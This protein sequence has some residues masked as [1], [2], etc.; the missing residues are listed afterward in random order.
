MGDEST[1]AALAL[2]G[3]ARALLDEIVALGADLDLDSALQRIIGAACRITSA[4]FGVLAV[5]GSSGRVIDFAF[6]GLDSEEQSVI[7]S[8]PGGFGLRG[9]E[10]P[11]PLTIDDLRHYLRSVGLPERHLPI[12]TFL[13]VPIRVRGTVF[14]N[15]YL[16][17]KDAG[18]EFTS[19]DE[20]LLQAL[21][22][23]AAIVVENARAYTQSERRRQWLEATAQITEALQPPVRLRS[24][25]QQIAI[26]ARR[27]SGAAAV[28]VVQRTDGHQE[29]VARDDHEIDLPM[30]VGDLERHIDR[31]IREPDVVIAPLA[32]EQKVILVPLRAMVASG[33]VLLVV[34]DGKRANLETEE[35]DML[36]SFADQASFALDRAQAIAD[37]AELAIVTDRDRIA[38]DLHD[39]V[40]QRLFATGLQLQGARRFA[41]SEEVMQRIDTAVADLDL[42]I[43][44]I[45]TTIFELQNAHRFSVRVDL[46]VLTKEYAPVLGFTPTVRTSG[47]VDTAISSDLGEQVRA[48]LREALANVARHAEASTTVVELEVTDGDA[49]LRVA[50]D[51]VGLGDD[52]HESG[53]CN[54]R[55]RAVERNGM[56]R[57]YPNQPRG[58]VL[59]WRVPLNT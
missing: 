35:S 44:D 11:K 46:S 41:G 43:R 59:E 54:L 52:L 56:L 53:L 27:V 30:L 55:Q 45:R 32:E 7:E 4:K 18:S 23:A 42:T 40:I 16:A 25:L 39:L 49:T 5:L 29:I 2:P 51:G 38:R 26:S 8:L 9:L 3:Q 20:T 33:G 21:A 10:A 19:Q 13:G 36:A 24:A 12:G 14:G 58:T 6:H 28:A 57:F 15:I 34:L 37:R 22:T 47:P 17:E 50:D 1:D 31:A 48:V